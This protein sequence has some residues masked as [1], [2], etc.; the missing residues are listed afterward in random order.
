M[1]L[2]IDSDNLIDMQANFV[3]S[4]F[5]YLSFSDHSNKLLAALFEWRGDLVKNNKLHSWLYEVKQRPRNDR[6]VDNVSPAAAGYSIQVQDLIVK[7]GNHVNFS[8]AKISIESGE[9]IRKY[10]SRCRTGLLIG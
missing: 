5:L 1:I 2:L 3:Y 10:W 7:M 8:A 6:V 9:R 4:I